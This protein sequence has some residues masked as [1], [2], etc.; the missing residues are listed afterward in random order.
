MCPTHQFLHDDGTDMRK[1]LEMK[2]RIRRIRR[3]TRSHNF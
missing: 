3:L 1:E 2:N